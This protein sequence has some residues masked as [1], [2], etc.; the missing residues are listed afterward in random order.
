MVEGRA[1]HRGHLA[2]HGCDARGRR[3]VA[4]Q[5][6]QPRLGQRIGGLI[7]AR[8]SDD[9]VAAA[10][11]LARDSRA[12][13][14]RCAGAPMLTEAE[15]EHLFLVAIGRP[16]K[17]PPASSKGVTPRLQRFLDALTFRPATVATAAWD[18]IAWNAAAPV[19]LTDYAALSRDDRHVLRRVFLDPETRAAQEDWE[20]IARYLV[21]TFRAETARAGVDD[22]AAALRAELSGTSAEF[23]AM[24]AANDAQLTG[25]SIK[26]IGHPLA[27]SITSEFSSFTVDGRPDLKRVTYTPARER[28]ADKMRRLCQGAG[29]ASQPYTA[30]VW[31]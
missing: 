29:K 7:G 23:N 1:D 27:R 15:R 4:P 30:A 25:A 24:W 31:P 16:A 3:D 5:D 10:A 19:A 17:A 12:D 28:N 6:V 22:R 14:A 9:I 20:S 2:R 26:R 11:H 13:K 21:A 18:I 8:G